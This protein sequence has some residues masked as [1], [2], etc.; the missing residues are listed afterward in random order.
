MS[1]QITKVI[2]QVQSP[3]TNG[4]LS[5]GQGAGLITKLNGVIA[6]FNAGQVRAACNQFNAFINQVYAFVNSGALSPEQG[7]ALI[8]AANNIRAQIGC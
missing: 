4:V 7:Q 6:K 2:T 3:V 1:Q 5:S 8:T